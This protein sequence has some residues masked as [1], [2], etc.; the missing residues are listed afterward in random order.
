MGLINSISTVPMT[1][2]KFASSIFSSV[3]NFLAAKVGFEGA[4]SSLFN[5]ISKIMYFVAKWML[6]VLDILFS[7][8][9]QLSGLEMKYDSLES[10]VSK[11]SDFVFNMLF[12]ATDL[13]NPIIRNLIGLSIALIIFFAILAV[14]KTQFNSLKSKTPADI[15]G[16]L[17]DTGRAFVLLVVTPMI[18][19]MGIVGSNLLLQSL[20]RATNTTNSNSISSSLFSVSATSASAYRI[21]A[22]EDMR[23]PITFDFTE[24]AEILEYYKNHAITKEFREY[25]NSNKNLIYYLGYKPFTEG[26]FSAFSTMNDTRVI[27]PNSTQAVNAKNYYQVYDRTTEAY[28]ALNSTTVNSYKKISAY[29][30][31][32]F[33]M[34]DVIDFGIETSTMLYFKTIQEVLETISQ[35]GDDYLFNSTVALYKIQFLDSDLKVIKR[36][37][38][39]VDT[40]T[41]TASSYTTY[42]EIYK[43]SWS[44]IRF[45]STYYD[46]NSE[47]EPS[48]KMQI[49]YNHVRDA[50]DE[51]Q[52]AKFI[53]TV[54]QSLKRAETRQEYVEGALTTITE[55]VVHTYYYP[56]TIGLLQ[57]NEFVFDSE[58]IQT[59]QLIAAKGIFSQERYGYPVPTAIRISEDGSEVQFYRHDIESVTVGD[60]DQA[61]TGTMKAEE[62]KGGFLSWIKKLFA[63]L[64]PNFD[65]KIDQDALVTAY[66]YSETV[67][68]VLPSGKLNVSY[69][70]EDGFSNNLLN[71]ATGVV[72]VVNASKGEE[73]VEQ[74]GIHGL[75]LENVFIP[76]K[77][78]MIILIC[79]SLMLVKIV[80]TAI[81]QL[82]NRGYELFL[83]IIVYPTA[84]ATIPIMDKDDGYKT[85][86]TTF[87]SRLF[88]TYGLVLGLNFVL[89]L[90][91]VIA[92]LEVFTAGEIALSK[93]I[94]R[95]RN[96]FSTIRTVATIGIVQAPI[97]FEFLAGFLNMVVVIIFQLVAFTLLE[98]I[99]ETISRITKSAPLR[100]VNPIES[101]KKVLKVVAA[102]VKTISSVVGG[103]KDF[104]M[105]AGDI[106]GKREEVIRNAKMKVKG[107]LPGSEIVESAKDFGNMQKKKHEQK[108]AMNELKDAMNTAKVSG[109]DEKDKT[110]EEKEQDKKSA[111]EIQDK[112]NKVLEAQDNYQKA[113][114]D[115]RGN[116]LAED[117]KRR[118]NERKGLDENGRV[119]SRDEG[120]EGKDLS[121]R[122]KRQLKKEKKRAKKIVKRLEKEQKLANKG[123]RGALSAEEQASL[124]KY[125]K[126]LENVDSAQ[127]E[128]KKTGKEISQAEKTIK[129]LTKKRGETSLTPEEEAQLQAAEA[130]VEKGKQAEVDNKNARTQEKTE[131][132]EKARKRKKDAKAEEKNNKISRAFKRT[133][134]GAK[135]AQKRYMKGVNKEANQIQNALNATGYM[136]ARLENMTA[137]ERK[138]AVES[139]TLT[140]E[141]KDM[142]AAY[143]RLMA[144]KSEKLGY[145]DAVY[146]SRAAQESNGQ[147]MKHRFK[148]GR[149]SGNRIEKKL[150]KTEE[151]EAQELEKINKELESLGATGDNSGVTAA[152]LGRVT[153]LK[154]RRQELLSRGQFRDYWSG[155]KESPD[156]PRTGGRNAMTKKEVKQEKKGLK[157]RG[158]IQRDLVEQYG[159]EITESELSE[160]TNQKLAKKKK[161]KKKDT[162]DY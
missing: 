150:M 32:Y 43:G 109:K 85:W 30:P 15:K 135:I 88:S 136:G 7:F 44:V 37:F 94:M 152:N 4:V 59:G 5:G 13:I 92:E 138:Q 76:N 56:L 120:D 139:G 104:I 3:P 160:R 122:T 155:K 105:I 82:I 142:F 20:Y 27:D 48:K 118:A 52:G 1:L 86:M 57:G 66:Q 96:L 132:K 24:H 54:Q 68:N 14:V 140:D 34:A 45:T 39:S 42:K 18:A 36:Q 146:A 65:V 117:D 22:Q 46:V 50:V 58:Y 53:M 95:F 157:K 12:T 10:M 21:Y 26:K 159:T 93:P 81:F 108:E 154:K 23:I 101:A 29:R 124:D 102:I 99:P 107:F 91:P 60:S 141:Q 121:H 51:I 55:D 74:M 144:D 125:S 71:F 40:A 133:G 62:D 38:E 80:F 114:A 75:L 103:I 115:P 129:K 90:F 161:K 148:A 47:S 87:V 143:E 151:S 131:R 113:L 84:C 100:G 31:E 17:K 98:T 35:T 33:V 119:S 130:T 16:V 149:R 72:N 11:E 8:I 127:K 73:S 89:M 83:T 67:V 110:P 70:F 112:F 78:N 147:R 64:N 63:F 69:M 28:E 106:G 145:A 134:L 126:I 25:V 137:E 97:S 162:S 77:I 116:R 19:I 2:M 9:R 41:E 128:Q 49:Q 153:K 61:G 79:G 123:K 6:Y 156:G 158:R 111:K